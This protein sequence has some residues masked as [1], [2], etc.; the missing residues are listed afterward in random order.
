M[1]KKNGLGTLWHA[2]GATVV[3]LESKDHEQVEIKYGES[4]AIS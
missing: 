2:N 1:E 4:V 3:W